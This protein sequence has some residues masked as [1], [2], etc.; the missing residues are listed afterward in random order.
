MGVIWTEETRTKQPTGPARINWR[1]PL[2]LGLTAA[3]LPTAGLRDQVTQE[4][5]TTWGTAPSLKPGRHGVAWDNTAA[6][7]GLMLQSL[8]NLATA[9]QTHIVLVETTDT[10]GAYAGLFSTSTA[11]GSTAGSL[12]FQRESGDSIW[13]SYGSSGGSPAPT[14][15]V[16]K[17]FGPTILV[18][19]GD[20]SGI[21]SWAGGIQIGTTAA[22]TPVAQSNCRI[23]LFGER[24][25]S[26]GNSTKAKIYGYWGFNR[27]L[28]NAEIAEITRNPWQLYEPDNAPLV[29]PVVGGGSPYSLD[30][31]AGSYTLTG[32]SAALQA[33]RTITAEAGSYSLTG[34]D[35]GLSYGH[36]LTAEAGAYTLTGVDASFKTSRTILAAAG[37]YVVSGQ[38]AT[39]TYTP[40]GSGSPYSMDA[41]A[42]SYT[43]TGVNATFQASRTI[44][45]EAGAYAL[46][47]VDASFT[48]SEYRLVAE[49]GSYVIS[50]QEATFNTTGTVTPTGSRGGT[51]TGR[52]LSRKQKKKLKA[53]ESQ[54]WLKAEETAR[55]L[56]NDRFTKQTPQEKAEALQTYV[57]SLQPVIEALKELTVP[58]VEIPEEPIIELTPHQ[59]ILTRFDT[60]EKKLKSV[61][62]LVII[63]MADL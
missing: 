26:V 45:A 14:Y 57:E 2:S 28:S 16:S 50:G 29:F 9:A 42:G 55:Q 8:R 61:E 17:A 36:A 44:V 51:G 21:T 4:L 25:A 33:A 27:R 3:V 41:D 24:F 60:L 62:E 56:L 46:T 34:V 47:G 5:W 31:E 58:E 48:R 32:V 63:L 59:E 19:S 49:T 11:D 20:S 52:N 43:I 35:A 12:S 54:E 23:V 30:G 37:S 6:F 39:F 13:T 15:L 38:D 1:S 53:V 22:N 40:V 18:L 7:G 10:S